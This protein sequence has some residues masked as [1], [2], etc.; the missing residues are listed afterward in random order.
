M[1]KLTPK[2]R[3]LSFSKR[4]LGRESET[5]RRL[6]EQELTR[7]ISEAIEDAKREEQAPPRAA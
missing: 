3:A 2:D 4:W 7:I 5:L 1:A 6:G